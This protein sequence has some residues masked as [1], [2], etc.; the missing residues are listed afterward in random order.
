MKTG[1]HLKL[2]L[3]IMIAC[4]LMKYGAAN[5]SMIKPQVSSKGY[6]GMN[7]ARNLGQT[8]GCPSH[9]RMSK[10]LRYEREEIPVDHAY[11]PDG[12]G[13]GG[14]IMNRRLCEEEEITPAV[15][16]SVRFFR[17]RTVISYARVGML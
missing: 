16:T 2:F 7:E 13:L 15:S 14:F 3:Q 10:A 8:E 4:L 5:C 12:L 17:S 1:I 11:W 6:L 9:Q